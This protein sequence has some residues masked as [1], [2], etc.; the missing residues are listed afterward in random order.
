MDASISLALAGPEDFEKFRS[1]LD[2][3][4]NSDGR[5]LVKHR[6]R[7]IYLQIYFNLWKRTARARKA[8]ERSSGRIVRSP[9]PGKSL[10]ESEFWKGVDEMAATLNL[11]PGDIEST[12]EQVIHEF[13]MDDKIPWTITSQDEVQPAGYGDDV[14]ILLF[15][16]RSAALLGAGYRSARLR[17][18]LEQVGTDM[19]SDKFQPVVAWIKNR[20]FEYKR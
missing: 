15:L 7:D 2:S 16:S 6:V 19:A 5:K 20:F 3:D 4:G 14:P 10:R 9:L 12:A 18:L 11:K 13:V 1:G 8:H 17:R